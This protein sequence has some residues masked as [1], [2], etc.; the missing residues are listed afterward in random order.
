MQPI[1]VFLVILN[2]PV[3]QKRYSLVREF[4]EVI[5][6]KLILKLRDMKN[7]NLPILTG[8]ILALV[9]FS[10]SCE[11]D[12]SLEGNGN[13]ITQRIA[14]QDFEEIDIDGVLNVY[15]KQGDLS[16]VEI[17]TDENLQ[18]I[19]E[20][21]NINGI[22]YV[23]TETNSEFDATQM[24]VFITAPSINKIDLDGVTALYCESSLYLD[25]LEVEKHNTGYMQLNTNLDQ[26]VIN[27]SGVGEMSLIGK[28]NEVIIDNTMT[29]DISA[30]GFITKSLVLS[31]DGTGDVEVFVL[32]YLEVSITGVGDV[33]CKGKPDTI[34]KSGEDIVGHLYM[35]D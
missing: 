32:D 7:Y 6:L 22:L 13:V 27:S 11:I 1:M 34:K 25:N 3:N 17:M 19:V 35:V 15:L 18:D 30:Y 12:N 29:G 5:G 31:H 28:G 10:T 14:V 21:E 23:S 24:D 16:K 8:M 2:K 4:N 26:L 20:V 33:Y 9:F